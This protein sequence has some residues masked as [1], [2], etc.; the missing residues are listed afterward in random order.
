MHATLAPTNNLH[1]G[2]MLPGSRCRIFQSASLRP[3]VTAKPPFG[4]P[5]L[6]RSLTSSGQRES[7]LSSSCPYPWTREHFPGLSGEAGGWARTAQA[8]DGIVVADVT[9]SEKPND[10]KKG[11][12]V[13][14]AG[15]NQPASENVQGQCHRDSQTWEQCLMGTVPHRGSV[16]QQV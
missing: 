4:H 2:K 16:T 13:N 14:P 5:C 6:S 3:P 8:Q 11:P 1:G 9:P 12:F 7:G 15:R 10:H